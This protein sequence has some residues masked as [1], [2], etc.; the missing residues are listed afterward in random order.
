[1]GRKCAGVPR[2]ERAR[3][4]D[5]ST[6]RKSSFREKKTA[7]RGISEAEVRLR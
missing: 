1:L 5:L 2:R 6:E 3:K 7:G 4:F